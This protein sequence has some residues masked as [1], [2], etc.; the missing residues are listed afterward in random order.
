MSQ[1]ENEAHQAKVTAHADADFYLMKKQSESN[2]V[3]GEECE[4]WRGMLDVCEGGCGM[5]GVGVWIGSVV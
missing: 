5:C 2:Q 4:M 1:I 3:C